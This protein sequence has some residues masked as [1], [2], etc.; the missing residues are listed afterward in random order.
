MGAA[1]RALWMPFTLAAAVYGLVMRA[2]AWA[3]RRGLFASVKAGVPVVVVGNLS[4]GGTGKTPLTMDIVER[5]AS[6]GRKPA[7]VSRGYRGRLEG[8][9]AVV[10]D[11]AQ[12]LLS[13]ADAGDE[14]VM[15]ARRL[16]G[17]PVVNGADR[18]VAV[19]RAAEMGADVVVCDDAFQHL[20][21]HRRLNIVSVDGRVAFGNRM[22]LPLGPL[23]EPLAA[24]ARADALVVSEGERAEEA[25]DAARRHGFTGPVL[26][27]RYRPRDVVRLGDGAIL[28]PSVFDGATV[29]A[30]AA[31]AN[32]ESFVRTLESLRA[33]V[34][35]TTFRRDHHPWC[36]EDW[37]EAARVAAR[38]GFM[39][40]AATEKDAVK[41]DGFGLP[42]GVPILVLRM[43][44]EWA[45]GDAERLTNLLME[46]L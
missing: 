22:T 39:Y 1:R 12:M 11:G 40:H 2:R 6:L 23:R 41:L 37:D 27:R 33:R 42:G 44:I 29:H 31:T 38:G 9:V 13:A 25:I 26:R 45:D 4:V 14:P 36:K 35:M 46:R 34:V 7:V 30:A 5:L 24:I 28:P 16:A 21:L 43:D 8:R 32:P 19:V 20:R 3:Y 10:S 15:M 18:P 17:T